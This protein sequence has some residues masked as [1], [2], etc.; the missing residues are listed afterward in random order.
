MLNSIIQRITSVARHFLPKKKTDIV[1]K[2]I[3][4]R[5]EKI[6]KIVFDEQGDIA[7][8][9]TFSETEVKRAN[10]FRTRPY[11]KLKRDAADQIVYQNCGE[12]SS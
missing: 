3:P 4:L 7:H 8:E 1:L 10:I 6:P 2:S 5:T 11:P 12:V 9:F